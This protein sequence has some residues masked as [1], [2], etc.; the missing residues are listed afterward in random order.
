ME[1]IFFLIDWTEVL[2]VA[3]PTA[4]A[5]GSA[6]LSAYLTNKFAASRH[7]E[8]LAS[9]YHELRQRLLEALIPQRLLSYQNVFLLLNDL[10]YKKATRASTIDGIAPHLM[11][12]DLAL[13]SQIVECLASGDESSEA[14]G[15]E[16]A[17]VQEKIRD[18]AG[19]TTL[20]SY[21]A[22]L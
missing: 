1:T 6:I 8:D 2:K 4:I 19:V 5:A 16:I 14:F 11:W 13:A 3:I 9:R 18:Q 21:F 20:E 22:N 10:K 15:K 7:Q 17:T 12:L